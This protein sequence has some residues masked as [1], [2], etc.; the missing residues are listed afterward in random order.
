MAE[1]IEKYDITKE[2]P[3]EE[4]KNIY[5]SAP[6]NR[7]NLVMGSQDARFKELDATEKMAVSVTWSMPIRK[8]V[9]WPS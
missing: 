5:S 1:A 8:T 7:Y 2:N 9:G 3:D 4:A 6:G